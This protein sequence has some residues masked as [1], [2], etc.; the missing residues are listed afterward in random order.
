MRSSKQHQSF[1]LQQAYQTA[2][3]AA[4]AA[5]EVVLPLWPAPSNLSFD[6][7]LPNSI[8]N[9]KEGIGNFSTSAD[10]QAERRIIEALRAVPA[11]ADH[12]I[13]SEEAGT[14]E[15][16][17]S[18]RWIIDPID[19]TLAFTHGLTHFGVCIGL[20]HRQ[21]PIL[22]AIAMPA[23]D[24]I[25]VARR[26]HGLQ[27]LTLAGKSARNPLLK[28]RARADVALAQAVVAY[29]I[30]YERRTEQ[31][32]QSAVKLAPNVAY[33]LSYG[34]AAAANVSLA[35]GTVDGYF[36]CTPTL[37]DIAAASAVV[38]EAGGVVS[39]F[40]GQ[41]I[42]W[43]ASHRTYLAAR[44]PALHRKLLSAIKSNQVSPL[45]DHEDSRQ[46]I[47]PSRAALGRSSFS[48]THGG[49]DE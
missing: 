46:M 28:V 8:Q 44:T 17:P 6:L 20:L 49:D 25:L 31:L 10:V 15:G 14:I 42:D 38:V 12:S 1:I 39:D 41:P 35:L 45:V 19:G 30:G 40:A 4:R 22:G 37:F 13:E 34:S 11:L 47:A 48:I 7:T 24:R 26:D 16:D 2:I 5:S 3:L 23:L 29:D 36:H 21:V 18:W 9:E 43:S 32:I 27:C 33:L